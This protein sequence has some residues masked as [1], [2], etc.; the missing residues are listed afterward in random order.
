MADQRPVGG[1][2]RIQQQRNMAGNQA[3]GSLRDQRGETGSA[4]RIVHDLDAVFLEQRGIV[5]TEVS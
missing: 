5:H 2:L 3:L 1:G 4:D